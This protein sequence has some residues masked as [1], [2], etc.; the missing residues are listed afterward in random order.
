[1]RASVLVS[2][3][4]LGSLYTGIAL[5]EACYVLNRSSSEAIPVVG[6][7]LCYEFFGAPEDAIDWSCSNENDQMINSQQRRL[8]HCDKAGS[9]GSCEAALTQETLTNYRSTGPNLEQFRPFV[10]NDAK[11]I[12][13]YYHTDDL[14]QLRIECEKVGGTWRD[15]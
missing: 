1:M 6:K 7:E 11:V 10:P 2:S 15:E 4:L 3:F 5:G 9:L 14:N 8:S 13:R 12:T